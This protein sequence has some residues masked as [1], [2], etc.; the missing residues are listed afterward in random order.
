MAAAHLP[1]T[2]AIFSLKNVVFRQL[3]YPL[4]TTTFTR[5]QSQQI[6][7]P[8]L[9]QGL[10]K[11]GVVRTFPHVLVHGPLDYGGLDIPHLFTKQ[12]IAHVTTILRYGPDHQDP[13]GLLLHAT[14]KAMRLEVGYKGELFAAPLQLADNVTSSWLKHVWVSTQ[15][16]EILVSTD[17]A[18]IPLQRHGDIE[19]M[20]LFVQT[21]W[22]QPVLHTL[23]QC[24][25]FL[26][27]FRLSDIVSGSGESISP[28]YWTHPTPAESD[29]EWPRTH[30]PPQS[31]WV[32]WKTALTSALHLGRN[33]SLA[34]PLGQWHAQHTPRGWFY[35]PQQTLYG[36]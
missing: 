12:M 27:V 25:M 3:C 29:L 4:V 34:I 26:R 6:M 31:A 1:S 16:A 11:A 9:Q 33:Q 2:D 22:K 32:L 24:R 19:L 28:N 14:G 20:R 35:H 15:E 30:T 36:S 13:T 5:H 7:A 18:D 8:I 21:G 10:P 17:F 23:N